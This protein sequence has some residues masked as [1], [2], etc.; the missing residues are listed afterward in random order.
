M[1]PKAL[2]GF[3]VC[4]S[5]S[6]PYLCMRSLLLLLS[7]VMVIMKYVSLFL[8]WSFDLFYIMEHLLAVVIFQGGTDLEIL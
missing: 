4:Y 5:T 7:V 6:K 3:G 1:R 8:H 2:L